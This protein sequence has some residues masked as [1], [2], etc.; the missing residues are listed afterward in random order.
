MFALTSLLFSSCYSWRILDLTVGMAYALLTVFGKRGK[1]IAAAA[2][3]LRGYH[4]IYPI[5]DL[6]KRHLHLL[7][8]C[9]LACSVTLGAYSLKQN[10]GNTYLLLHSQ[11]AWNALELIWGYTA[12]HF[13]SMRSA[14][15]QVFEQACQVGGNPACTDL[16]MPDPRFPDVLKSI[17]VKDLRTGQNKRTRLS[18]N[19]DKPVITFVTGNKKKLEEVQ[20]ILGDNLPFRITNEEVDLPELQGEPLEIAKAKCNE[21]ASLIGGAVITEDTSLCF[22]ALQGLP[23]PYI[24]WF[25]EKCGHAG[26]NGMIA[27][28]QDKSAYAQTVVAFCPGPGQHVEVFDGR[29][30]GK[31]VT[32]RGKL[33][34][35]WD[36]VFEPDEGDG[37]TYAEMS[38]EEKD[39][40]SHRSR[41]M[42]QL[43][44]YLTANSET[45]KLALV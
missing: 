41:A 19:G 13:S 44:T 10:P 31:I 9:R 37:K 28:F 35:G 45:V 38:K 32:A 29:T 15:N 16:D 30:M 6:E 20:R 34:F 43:K 5:Q 40:I 4:S 26:L 1:S 17:R 42:A 22:T 36:P 24:K 12:E 11:P 27:A 14:F 2:A 3:M 23:G 21:A 33:E 39:A 8:A 7:T 18:D 25:L